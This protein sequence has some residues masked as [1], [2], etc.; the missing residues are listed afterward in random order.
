MKSMQRMHLLLG[1]V[2]SGLTLPL[3][4]QIFD[5]VQVPMDPRLS[6]LPYYSFNQGLGLTTPDSTYSMNI[7]FRMQLRAA[8]TFNDSG[9]VSNQWSVR[10]LRLRFDGF[11]FVPQLTYAIQLSFATEDASGE[12]D[13]NNLNLI[14]DAVLFYRI[15]NR[16][17]VGFGQTKLPGNR[18]RVN[19]SSALQLVD[20][21]IANAAFTIDRDF[22]F[23]GTYRTTTLTNPGFIVRTSISSGK[24]RNWRGFSGYGLC[25]T[26]RVEWYPLGDFTNNGVFIEGDLQREPKPKVMLGGTYSFND[27]AIRTQGQLGPLLLET[28]DLTSGFVDLLFKYRGWAVMADFMLR[29]ANA[30][31]TTNPDDTTQMNAV[32]TGTG[33]N[34]QASYLFKNNYEITARYARVDPT[35]AVASFYPTTEEIRLGVS[36]YLRG[37]SLKLQLDG[38]LNTL[39]APSLPKENLW[40]I[41]FQIELGI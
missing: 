19:S 3:M 8:N 29:D 12:V 26:G 35:Q 40:N 37:H 34:F 1:L 21:S 13:N 15:N 16:F 4:G 5:S 31:V 22:G 10:R 28:R 25:Y 41:R 32:L 33:W 38:G 27:N 7:R 11:A 18:Q 6:D 30:P 9:I 23:F 14:R 20:R 36:K 17:T 2:F 24:G 39:Q